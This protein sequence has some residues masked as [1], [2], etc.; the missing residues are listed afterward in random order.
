MQISNVCVGNGIE[1]MNTNKGKKIVK[2]ESGVRQNPQHNFDA[3]LHSAVL[4]K[5]AVNPA[6]DLQD[7]SGILQDFDVGFLQDFS[8]P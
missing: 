7:F 6:Q 1:F 3:D 2:L 8:C 4:Q 5:I